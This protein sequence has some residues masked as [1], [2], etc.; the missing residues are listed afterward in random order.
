M[1]KLLLLSAL[2]IFT[3]LFSNAQCIKGDCQDGEGTYK[4]SEGN[5]IGVFKNGDAFK[6]VFTNIRFDRPIIFEGYFIDTE[7]GPVLDSTK[8]GKM[9]YSN[10]EREGFITEVVAIENNSKR[11]KWV[12]N[13]LG[14]KK[15]SSPTSGGFY[16]EKGN[17]I[18]DVLNDKNAIIIYPNGNKYFGGV[19]NGKRQGIGKV[20][21]PDGGIQQDGNWYD[22]EWI[23][24]NTNNPYAVPIY[25]NGYSIMVDVD[26]NGTLIKMTLDTGASMT[27]LNEV[28]FYSLLALG[29]IKIKNEE[30]GRFTIANGDVVYGKTYVI[31]KMKI[32]NYEIENIEFS[33]LDE[34]AP[35]LLGLNALL[36]IS[37]SF[38]IDVEAGELTF[39]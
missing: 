18:N 15:S 16:A 33:V 37:N 13:G 10:N 31:D 24:A 34:N 23:D 35:D 7:N 5:F 19:V 11:Y 36:E 39:N 14:E 9:F 2:L 4:Y 22:G 27:S 38:N 26:F 28:K 30:D 21:T 1:K 20:I 32:G 3:C 12:L 6:G 17:F 8:K 25:Y 29:Q